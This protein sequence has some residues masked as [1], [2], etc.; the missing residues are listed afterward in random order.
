MRYARTV[1][2]AFP[3]LLL[4]L[5]VNFAARE[6]HASDADD[7]DVR[8][9]VARISFLR[10]DV[11]LRRAGSDKWER[12]ARNLPL[13]EGDV[14]ATAREAR[15]EIQIDRRNFVRINENSV[16]R[17]VTLRD[18]GVALSLSEGTASVRLAKFDREREYFEID[19]PNTTL[20]AERTGLYRIDAPSSGVVRLTVRDGG[21]ARI[22][23]ETS[24]FTLRDGRMAEL[25]PSGEESGDWQL[26]AA[27]PFDGWDEWT[28][29]REQYL[30]ARSRYDDRD[31]YY[32]PSLWGAEE[33]DAYGDWTYTE[34]YGYVW[35][36]RASVINN[37]NNWAPYRYGQWRWFPPYGW[38][39]V[40]DE[41]WGWAPYHYGRWV[42]YNNNW[43]WTP[44]ITLALSRAVWRP[45]L[46]VFVNINHNN[47]GNQIA[48]Y[49][50]RYNQPDPRGRNYRR[51]TPLRRD[52]MANLE[53]TNPA[54]LRAVTTLPA[55]DFGAQATASA[56]ARPATED[57]ARRVVA[58]EPARPDALPARPRDLDAA[59]NNATNE[60]GGYRPADSLSPRARPARPAF[61]ADAPARE[62]P[63]R[64]TGAAERNPGQPLD[65]QLRRTRL[66]NNR[67]PRPS[68]PSVDATSNT[69]GVDRSVGNI[70]NT[71]AVERPAR[72]PRVG[73]P[74]RDDDRGNPPSRGGITTDDGNS[75]SDN[76]NGTGVSEPE[77]R[78]VR[79]VRPAVPRRQFPREDAPSSGGN[80]QPDRDER[81]R[82][83]PGPRPDPPPREEAP[84]RQEP[85]PRIER[86]REE[87][88][89]REREQPATPPQ[90]SEPPQR[91]QREERPQRE[92][93]EERPARPA[94]AERPEVRDQR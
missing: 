55:R 67:E 49:P 9:R 60:R 18:E 21:R 71:G 1:S 87:A 84:T 81:R 62:L 34:Q 85:P 24:G 31:R 23:S 6:V 32:D 73:R 74:P 3:L 39:W 17:I 27:L 38:T 51:L 29:D 75:S 76:N 56:R 44:R 63:T 94:R 42:Y 90:R 64:A 45:A 50:L 88:P 19:A 77:E 47:Y 82:A 91:E 13:V 14:V 78:R 28:R 36:P 57:L 5:L 4:I 22:Y 58:S 30:I 93:R 69:G 92:Q 7:Y 15:V 61:G 43:C 11:T 72:P 48:W 25:L 66:Y 33:L 89:S 46:V 20:A 16:L 35:R 83:A 12:A 41:P 65:D 2:A 79:P 26:A 86:P 54:Y 59:T 10:G 68:P 53:R 52:E 70:D 8:A 80:E 40:G 37:Y